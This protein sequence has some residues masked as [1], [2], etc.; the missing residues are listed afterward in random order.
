MDRIVHSDH[1]RWLH[2]EEGWADYDPRI[3]LDTGACHRFRNKVWGYYR[4]NCR[5]FE[6]R[7]EISSY[8]VFVSEI[9]LQQTQTARVVPKFNEFIGRFPDFQTL[10]SAPFSEVL[11]Y[12][13]GLGYNRRAKYLQESAAAIHE[14]YG[15]ILPEDPELLVRLPGIGPATAASMIVFAHNLP[16]AFVET[17]IRTV[18]I[19]FFFPHHHKVRDSE[20]MALASRTLDQNDP[21]QW[22]YALMDYGVMLKKTVGNFGRKSS[23]YRKQSR[24]QG[25]DR[26]LRG[27]ILQILLDRKA[28]SEDELTKLLPE[29]P[30]RLRRV[31][32]GLCADKIIV[33]RSNRLFLS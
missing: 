2:T 3:G 6:W 25:S 5:D 29:T 16:L 32:D 27:M 20:V 1:C 22:Y 4:A 14:L 12:W 18:F 21:R 11:R 24:F 28:V 33:S 15:D 9:M 13:K 7:Q 31:I 30:G 8:R 17:N 23:S 26:Q 19:Y 10:A